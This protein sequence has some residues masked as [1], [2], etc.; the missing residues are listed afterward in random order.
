VSKGVICIALFI[1]LVTSANAQESRGKVS[2]GLAFSGPTFGLSIRTKLT[3]RFNGRLI[4]LLD[5]WYQAQIQF[6]PDPAS[7]THYRGAI[8]K[9]WFNK[10]PLSISADAGLNIPIVDDDDDF[11][12]AGISTAFAVIVFAGVGIHYEFR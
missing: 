1:G 2:V 7:N 4:F 6:K 8:G 12:L 3:D 9:D 10:G 11:G 5:D